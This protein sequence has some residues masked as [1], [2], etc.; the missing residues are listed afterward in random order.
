MA[1]PAERAVRPVPGAASCGAYKIGGS[2]TSFVGSNETERLGGLELCD[3]AR[4][5]PWLSADPTTF[6]LAPGASRAVTVTL[7]ATAAAGVD[8]P[9]KYT[10]ELGL[11]ARHPVPDALGRRWR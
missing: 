4:D 9:G 5:V 7:T 11:R 8:Q 10:A 3:E 2:P 6:T 1:G